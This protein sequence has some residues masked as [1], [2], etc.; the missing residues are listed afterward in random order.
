MVKPFDLNELLTRIRALLRRGSADLT[1][2]LE[3]VDLQLNPN[4]Y[5][6]T[7]TGKMLHLTPKEYRILELLLRHNRTK[8]NYQTLTAQAVQGWLPDSTG[9]ASNKTRKLKKLRCLECSWSSLHSASFLTDFSFLRPLMA[10]LVALAS[11]FQN[12]GKNHPLHRRF[13]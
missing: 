4:N 6:V 12:F 5:E 9:I 10:T 1:M 2:L 11:V 3:C 8:V 7:Y 13:G